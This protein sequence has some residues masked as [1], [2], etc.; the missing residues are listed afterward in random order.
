M[1]E[2]L[3]M[4]EEDRRAIEDDVVKRSLGTMA[5]FEDLP[6][7]R[8]LFFE[9]AVAAEGYLQDRSEDAVRQQARACVANSLLALYGIEVP[10]A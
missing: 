3:T 8:D 4:T 5:C 10:R 7:N 9:A 1:S 6:I 2:H